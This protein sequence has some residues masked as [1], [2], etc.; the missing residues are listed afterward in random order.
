M[1][2]IFFYK[3]SG[4]FDESVLLKIKRNFYKTKHRG[5]DNS[6][7]IIVGNNTFIGFHRLSINDLSESG[8]QPFVFEDVNGDKSYLICN[9]E[10]YNHKDIQ[11]KYNI[12]C[13]TESDCEVIY[14]LY[15]KIGIE[16][17]CEN[18]D[19]VFAFLIYHEKDGKIVMA[20][21]TVG[22]R[23]MFFSVNKDCI[24]VCS[25]GKGIIDLADNVRQFIPS[26]HAVY[27]SSDFKLNKYFAVNEEEFDTS[28]IEHVYERVRTVFIDAVNKRLMSDRPIGCLLSGGLDSS[29][30]AAILS[31]ELKKIGK[32]LN[33]YS[34]GF[35][36]STDLHYAKI[37]A[38]YIGSNHHEVLMSEEN[39]YND[40]EKIVTAIES[41]DTTT[42][43]AS[44]GMYFVSEYIKKNTKDVVIYSGE[45]ADELMQ[46]YLYFHY[47]PD[48]MKGTI[49]S[50]RLM[51]DLCYFDVLR[52]DR[53]TAAHGLEV[54]VPFLDIDFMSLIRSMPDEFVAPTKNIEKY[55]V[56][57]AFD[58]TDYLPGE[59]L[60]R[61][62]EAFSDGVSGKKKSWHT[63]IKDKCDDLFTDQQ[64]ETL[65]IKFLVN[66]PK[67]KEELLYRFYFE[68]HYCDND[69]WIPYYWLPRWVDQKDPSA[70]EL[71]VYRDR[72]SDHNITLIK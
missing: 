13:K 29:L 70:R 43:R 52:C 65:K 38:D 64:F 55:L 22:V 2:G 36:G 4:E 33:T 68:R 67:S 51:R 20:R 9:G 40:L 25:E 26:T 17:T 10:I 47:A 15:K 39:A 44:T 8:N 27:D 54:R 28:N 49:E 46:G 50:L 18:L 72:D 53:T 30:V 62:K 31:S 5:P 45:G 3:I 7:I 11:K 19:G 16:K 21:D 57:K 14:H 56:R 1:C 63:F 12:Q 69:D 24:A 37:V 23:P 71:K 42:I 6:Q 32:K 59:I 58:S 61:T 48:T 60:W 35:E 34:I 41:W 66:P